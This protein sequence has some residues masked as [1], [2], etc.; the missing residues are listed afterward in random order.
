MLPGAILDL[1]EAGGE[2]EPKA[3][4]RFRSSSLHTQARESALPRRE[5][6]RQA[7]REIL[8]ASGCNFLRDGRGSHEVWTCPA[9]TKRFT[10][11]IRAERSRCDMPAQCALAL[12]SRLSTATPARI[13]PIPT[14][15]QASSFCPNTIQ[16]IPAMSTMPAPDQTA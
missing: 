12:D 4:T 16:P 13:R 6:L 8:K 14:N 5:R 2:V 11:P 1:L 7:V 10:V 15:A 3:P 9:A